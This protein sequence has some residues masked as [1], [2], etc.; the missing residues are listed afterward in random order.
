MSDLCYLV[1][2]PGSA[3]VATNLGVT[4]DK[5]TMPL[6]ASALISAKRAPWQKGITV[7]SAQIGRQGRF[8]SSSSPLRPGL[9][10][11]AYRGSTTDDS[12]VV[13]LDA[14]KILQV[15]RAASKD[16]CVKAFEKL[17]KTAPEAEFSQV[18]T[19][20]S[21]ESILERNK[22]EINVFFDPL[23]ISYVLITPRAR[24]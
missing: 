7:R 19:P 14:F 20:D 4:P 22:W 21:F 9:R 3:G 2:L 8:R 13:P 23:L 12:V 6:G 15:N 1:I 24:Q 10:I 17:V 5:Y 18:R 16:T 11:V